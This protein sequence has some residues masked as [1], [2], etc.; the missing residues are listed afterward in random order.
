MIPINDLI[1]ELTRNDKK[2]LS[3]KALKA[4]EE[5][6]SLAKC[7]LPYEGGHGTN[8]RFITDKKILEEC[9]DTFLTVRS[10]AYSLGFSDEEW[11]SMVVSKCKNGLTFSQRKKSSM[12]DTRTSIEFLLNCM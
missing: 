4:Q 1:K 3:G 7:V 11:D 8:H 6:G 9:V 5:V 2:T 12:R 10:I